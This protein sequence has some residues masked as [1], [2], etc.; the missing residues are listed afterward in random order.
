MIDATATPDS[1][2]DEQDI[3]VAAASLEQD[4]AERSEIPEQEVVPAEG[5]AMANDNP[6]LSS[7]KE[8]AGRKRKAL[9]RGADSS[10]DEATPSK[11]A[12]SPPPPLADAPPPMLEDVRLLPKERAPMRALKLKVG[13]RVAWVPQCYNEFA[14]RYEA[15]L[16]ALQLVIDVPADLL[17]SP[18]DGTAHCAEI[19]AI[20]PAET[21]GWELLTLRGVP[22]DGGAGSSEGAEYCLPYVPR[23]LCDVDQHVCA[24]KEYLASRERA[25]SPSASP[26]VR[27][28]FAAP[29]SEGE[30]E[31]W[32]GRVWSRKPFDALNYPDSLYRCLNCVWYVASPREHEGASIQPLWVFDEEQTDNQ[33]SPWE[34]LWYDGSVSEENGRASAE[35][36]IAARIS[37]ISSEYRIEVPEAVVQALDD[38]T[39]YEVLEMKT[40]RALKQSLKGYSGRPKMQDL[41]SLRLWALQI[42]VDAA[43]FRLDSA[44][45]GQA[46]AKQ[47]RQEASVKLI[48]D[49]QRQQMAITRFD[50]TA[51]APAD[52][53]LPPMSPH[54]FPRLYYAGSHAV[55]H[56]AIVSMPYGDKLLG[57]LLEQLGAEAFR[58]IWSREM[59]AFCLLTGLSPDL[60]RIITRTGTTVDKIVRA[61][62]EALQYDRTIDTPVT[63]LVKL[64]LDHGVLTWDQ[65]GTNINLGPVI[66]ALRN[67]GGAGSKVEPHALLLLSAQ[68]AC[69]A[70]IIDFKEVQFEACVQGKRFKSRLLFACGYTEATLPPG[71]AKLTYV[72]GY[73]DLIS[74][75]NAQF[76]TDLVLMLERDQQRFSSTGKAL[77]F[78]LI[79]LDPAG[80]E[81]SVPYNVTDATRMQY[82]SVYSRE[83]KESTLYTALQGLAEIVLGE[84]HDLCDVMQISTFIG[85]FKL[86]FRQSLSYDWTIFIGKRPQFARVISVSA[87]PSD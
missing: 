47:A 31:L 68:L 80:G 2:A 79:F 49:S 64:L 58:I 71:I 39:I 21:E 23:R 7:M 32:E 50:P 85:C 67:T 10:D 46:A 54:T 77:P 26:H 42:K 6:D 38:T 69:K 82:T 37:W 16:D 33:V 30:E 76:H 22:F 62:V 73:H 55:A 56:P 40:T 83:L 44:R 18:A 5:T 25:L 63:R 65:T 34:L 11:L 27:V 35:A 84:G 51:A 12:F 43:P 70:Q 8:N 1:V 59:T 41:N 78:T 61:G 15:E 17:E 3:C 20:H 14:K 53:Y 81:E 86:S 87:P 36:A 28:P 72:P 66:M 48:V 57:G 4:A 19:V 75:A 24:L 60:S 29:D 45:Q 74:I 52:A 9:A 13:A